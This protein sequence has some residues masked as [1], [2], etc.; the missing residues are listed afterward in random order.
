M[1]NLVPDT[2]RNGASDGFHGPVGCTN[3]TSSG[4]NGA[5]DPS[6]SRRRIRIGQLLTSLVIAVCVV[7][8][9][10]ALDMAVTGDEASRLPDAI[11]R[12]DPVRGATQVPQQSQVFVDLAE[13][14]TG[15]IVIDGLEL[16]T[17]DLDDLRESARPGQQIEIPPT[18]IYEQG[19]AT[20]T[21]D[22]VDGSSIERFEQGEHVVQVIYWKIVEGRAKAQSFSWTFQVF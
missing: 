7:A 16:E 13:G 10:V 4:E 19:N 5:V 20:L 15:V 18:T 3:G 17:V 8:I 2:P 1:L 11:E 21:F 22:P 12:I 6:P 9:F 14:Y